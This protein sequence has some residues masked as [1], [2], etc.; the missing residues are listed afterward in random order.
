MELE[1]R[2]YLKYLRIKDLP[3]HYQE[4]SRVIGV[5]ATLKLSEAFPGIPLYFKN[6]EKVLREAKKAY[7]V[8]NFTGNNHRQL[9]IDTGFALANVYTILND[10]KE[11]KRAETDKEPK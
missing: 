10:Y 7:I 3:E 5:L 6:I 8:D 11:K 4:A 2:K 1:E 9:A